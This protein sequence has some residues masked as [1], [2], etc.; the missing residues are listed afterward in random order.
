V[1]PRI[2]AASRVA[3]ADGS[4]KKSPD[5]MVGALGRAVVGSRAHLLG[6]NAGL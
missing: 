1:R 4:E 2:S 5:A 6:V 3:V